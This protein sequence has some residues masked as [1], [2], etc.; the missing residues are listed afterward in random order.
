MIARYPLAGKRTARVENLNGGETVLENMD[1]TQFPENFPKVDYRRLPD[2]PGAVNLFDQKDGKKKK[3]SWSLPAVSPHKWGLQWARVY[4]FTQKPTS[5]FT[6]LESFLQNL[7]TNG[8]IRQKLQEELEVIT[9]DSGFKKEVFICQN[10]V[11]RTM[12]YRNLLV[13]LR[14]LIAQYRIHEFFIVQRLH[15]IFHILWL[16]KSK[17]KPAMLLKDTLSQVCIHRYLGSQCKS[18]G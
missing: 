3:N 6:A 7:K 18:S 9:F 13:V 8:S 16:Q 4:E 12:Y 10:N 1:C 17:N 5:N 15:V 11:A 2:F 14:K